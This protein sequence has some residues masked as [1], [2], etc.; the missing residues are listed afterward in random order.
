MVWSGL[1]GNSDNRANSVQLQAGTELGKNWPIIRAPFA[2]IRAPFAVIR[3]PPDTLIFLR[4]AL[5]E[6]TY[7]R[8]FVPNSFDPPSPKTSNLAIVFVSF[9]E[10]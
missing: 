8:A 5:K 10:L 6:T 7:I 9:P 4:G 3:A 1:V 2:V